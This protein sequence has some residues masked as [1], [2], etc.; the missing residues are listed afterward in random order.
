MFV[1]M[2]IGQM[3]LTTGHLYFCN[4]GHNPPVIGGDEQHGSFL[5]MESNAPIGLWPGIEYIGEEIETIKGRPLFIYSDG[6]TEFFFKLSLLSFCCATLLFKLA[7]ESLKALRHI[8]EQLPVTPKTEVQIT[9]FS[10][11]LFLIVFSY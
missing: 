4:A 7:W 2:F 9:V 1:T 5:E 11:I 6:L 8:L 3:N 10:A